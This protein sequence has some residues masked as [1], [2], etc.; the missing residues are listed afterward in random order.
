[1]AGK[2]LHVFPEEICPPFLDIIL[3][4]ASVLLYCY[5]CTLIYCLVLFFPFTI[6]TG[7]RAAPKA[8]ES[9]RVPFPIQKQGTGETVICSAFPLQCSHSAAWCNLF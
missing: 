1:M 5:T 2:L 4:I 8:H 7:E 6:K 3:D 9:A